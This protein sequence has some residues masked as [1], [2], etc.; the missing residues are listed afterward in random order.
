VPLGSARYGPQQVTSSQFRGVFRSPTPRRHPRRAHPHGRPPLQPHH[1]TVPVHRPHRRGN[2]N[3]YEYC[4]A[5]PINCTDLDGR[6]GWKK[7]AKRAL[8]NKWVRG[9]AVGVVVG[10]VCVRSAGIGCAI[11]AGAIAGG[12]LGGANWYVNHRRQSAWKHIARGAFDGAVGGGRN[13][14]IARG[15]KWGASRLARN[16]TRR[17]APRHAYPA[18]RHARVGRGGRAWRKYSAAKQRFQPSTFYA[19]RKL[20]RSL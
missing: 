5:D 6:F 19:A 18:A 10:A 13:Y 15:V 20:W 11:A 2:V 17:W 3:A 7:W 1:R 12:A 14:G 4:S 16:G 8:N 9:V